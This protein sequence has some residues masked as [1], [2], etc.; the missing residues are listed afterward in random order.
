M[1]QH[2]AFCVDRQYGVTTLE[3]CHHCQLLF[4]LPR[5][6]QLKPCLNGHSF[7]G[8]TEDLPKGEFWSISNARHSRAVKR[9]LRG[10]LNC[11]CLGCEPGSTR[12]I[13]YGCSWGYTTW[14]LQN[15]GDRAT[16]YEPNRT[17][18]EYAVTRMGVMAFHSEHRLSG[19]FDVFYCSHVLEHVLSAG[20]T[21]TLARQLVRPGGWIVFLTPNGCK[22]RRQTES[23]CVVEI[24]GGGAS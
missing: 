4:R 9:M 6:D 3:R 17:R 5:G 11:C 10:R 2:G 16:R 18:C 13:D 14:Q 8:M 20:R 23:G 1:R 22:S 24:L 21:L 12:I 15:A 7:A 19:R